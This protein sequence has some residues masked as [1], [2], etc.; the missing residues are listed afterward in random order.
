M[1]LEIRRP[2][3]KKNLKPVPDR[4]KKMET[5]KHPIRNSML[6]TMLLV[7]LSPLSGQ[8]ANRLEKLEKRL[9]AIEKRLERIE[10]VLF[11]S[12]RYSEA[13]A[14][15]SLKQAEESL[16]HSKKLHAKGYISGLKL[17]LDQLEFDRANTL[18]R[19]CVQAEDHR[20]IS[21]SLSVFDAQ[22][23]LQVKKMQLERSQNLLELGL[24][25]RAQMRKDEEEIQLAEEKLAVAKI[26][27]EALSQTELRPKKPANEGSDK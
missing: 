6:L 19:M 11:A 17:Q 10:N 15:K 22:R 23:N 7:S 4:E 9:E 5:H 8:E 26:K 3:R 21:A 25:A 13:E 18:L 2:L 27:L 14:R 24:I 12:I 1:I 20:L 16:K